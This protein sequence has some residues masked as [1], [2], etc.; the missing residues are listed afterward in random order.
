MFNSHDYGLGASK[1]GRSLKGKKKKKEKNNFVNRDCLTCMIGAN[2]NWVIDDFL[3][4]M[5]WSRTFF[6]FLIGFQ[7]TKTYAPCHT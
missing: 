7:E 3:I 5:I 1:I 4:S 2:N 6:F